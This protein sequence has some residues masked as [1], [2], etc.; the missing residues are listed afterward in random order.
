MEDDFLVCP[1]TPF[2]TIV[3]FLKASLSKHHHYLALF[4]KAAALLVVVEIQGDYGNFYIGCECLCFKM[5]EI[6]TQRITIPLPSN[7]LI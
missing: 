5:I 1:S 2:F 4:K 6:N 3:K 7:R